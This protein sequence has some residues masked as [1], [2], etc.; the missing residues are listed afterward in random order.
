MPLLL[1]LC[2]CLSGVIWGGWVRGKPEARLS[3]TK[4]RREGRQLSRSGF[5]DAVS[6]PTGSGQVEGRAICLLM[7]SRATFLGWIFS[8]RMQ[9][10]WLDSSLLSRE[11]LAPQDQGSLQKKQKE[12]E[13]KEKMRLP[14]VKCLNPALLS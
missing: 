12:K 6:Q 5:E 1:W 13:R 4:V 11:C 9:K 7:P 14:D 8:Q 10:M 3:Y 2:W